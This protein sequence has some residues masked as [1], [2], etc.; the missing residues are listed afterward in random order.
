MRKS[1]FS[2]DFKVRDYE[3]DLQGVVNNA[4]YLN[5]FEHTRHE[6]LLSVGFD[7]AKLSKEDMLPMVYKSEITYKVSLKS[8]DEFVSELSVTPFGEYKVIYYQN[9]YRKDNHRIIAKAKI[10]KVFVRDGKPHPSKFYLD[11]LE[12][13]KLI[14]NNLK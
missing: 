8:G 1:I 2:L 5:Y 3:C 14:N 6:F 7:F 12:T 13:N 4:V 11:L 10:T 9:L